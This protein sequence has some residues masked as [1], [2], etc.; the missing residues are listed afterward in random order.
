MLVMY[1][2]GATF[3]KTNKNSC[4]VA[5]K[6]SFDTAGLHLFAFRILEPSPSKDM[7]LISVT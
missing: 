1:C 5:R 6:F 2:T 3:G 4:L 7:M